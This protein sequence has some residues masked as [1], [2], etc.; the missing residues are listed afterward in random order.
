VKLVVCAC[1]RHVRPAQICPFC[2]RLARPSRASAERA[3]KVGA[4]VGAF[5]ALTMVACRSRQVEL[6]GSPPMPP[7][8]IDADTNAANGGA[9]DAGDARPA[10]A[11]V[12]AYGAPPLI[13]PSN[14]PMR[15][16]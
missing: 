12:T 2:R 5:V 9:A 6:Y 14:D 1:G 3:G 11:I 10:D 7:T 4:R 13:K 16:R 15:R 8:A